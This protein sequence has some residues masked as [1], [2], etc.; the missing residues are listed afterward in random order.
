MNKLNFISS[1]MVSNLNLFE[2][3]ISVDAKILL[4]HIKVSI[5][6]PLKFFFLS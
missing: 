5:T 3:N 6:R 2:K 4:R 1:F